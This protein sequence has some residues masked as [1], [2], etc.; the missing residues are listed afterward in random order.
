MPLPLY[1]KAPLVVLVPVVRVTIVIV[2]VGRQTTTLEAL[3]AS[4]SRCLRQSLEQ[5]L[6]R[7][8]VEVQRRLISKSHCR[9]QRQR[10]E[11]YRRKAVSE[12]PTNNAHLPD[13]ARANKHINDA[14]AYCTALFDSYEV[15]TGTAKF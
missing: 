14:V 5:S 11:E 4:R 10:N 3:T 8:V 7:G 2:T 15:C 6:E 1:V 13:G 12:Q 9:S